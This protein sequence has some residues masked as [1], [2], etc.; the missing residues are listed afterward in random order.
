[1]ENKFYEVIKFLNLGIP[2]V[3]YGFAAIFLIKHEETVHVPETK[4]T[5]KIYF[6]IPEEKGSR[7]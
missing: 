3:L 5:V 2:L 1:M 4:A 7:F 6:L